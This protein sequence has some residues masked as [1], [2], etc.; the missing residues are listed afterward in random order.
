M[1]ESEIANTLR[2]EIEHL[3]AVNAALVEAL[4]EIEGGCFAM[5]R[6]TTRNIARKALSLAREQKP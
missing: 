4:E 5:P 3:R 1:S 2:A 6:Q